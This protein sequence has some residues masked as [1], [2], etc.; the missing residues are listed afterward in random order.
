M[1]KLLMALALMMPAEAAAATWKKAGQSYD[2]KTT[3]WVD[4][5]SI[6][7]S[8]TGKT[9]WVRL[10]LDN[11]N[12]VTSFIAVRCSVKSYYEAKMVYYETDGNSNDLTA[13]QPK[14]KL[15][16]PDSI[17]DG[18]LDVVCDDTAY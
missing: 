14:W 12:W 8:K 4:V 2:E 1:K 15:A 6:R 13:D 17:M 16:T 10:N 7:T 9:A 11:G 5:S 18:I 3:G